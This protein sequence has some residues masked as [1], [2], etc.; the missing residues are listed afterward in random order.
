MST[1]KTYNVQINSSEGEMISAETNNTTF[2]HEHLDCH[3]I[4]ALT[5]S[6]RVVNSEGLHSDPIMK[7]VVIQSMFIYIYVYIRTYIR[8]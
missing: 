1:I 5:V 4:T 2:F 8:T 7:T 3:T 6:I